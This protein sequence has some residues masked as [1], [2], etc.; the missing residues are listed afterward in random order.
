MTNALFESR[1]VLFIVHYSLCISLHACCIIRYSSCVVDFP[2]CAPRHVHRPWLHVGRPARPR[3]HKPL[4]RA[5]PRAGGGRHTCN[6]NEHRVEHR[7]EHR[8]EH[9]VEHMVEHRVERMVERPNRV[10]YHAATRCLRQRRVVH[11]PRVPWHHGAS[12]ELILQL[13]AAAAVVCAQ[14][15]RAPSRTSNP[16]ANG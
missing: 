16:T 1:H 11:S 2:T 7:D 8:V 14:V 6:S 15:V 10:T 13:H 12:H 5:L 9:R 3:G 4:L